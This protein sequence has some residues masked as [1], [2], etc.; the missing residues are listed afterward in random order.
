MEDLGHLEEEKEE[1]DL[2]PP[3]EEGWALRLPPQKGPLPVAVFLRQ[4][5][6]KIVSPTQIS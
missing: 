3:K 6:S 4:K 2:G 1:K 5:S